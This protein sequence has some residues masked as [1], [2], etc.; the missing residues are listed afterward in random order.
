MMVGR[1]ISAA[2][3][4]PAAL[5]EAAQPELLQKSSHL[6]EIRRAETNEGYVLNLGNA[7]RGG[8]LTSADMA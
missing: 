2:S 5:L 3:V 4:K 6:V 8:P 7:H 1:T